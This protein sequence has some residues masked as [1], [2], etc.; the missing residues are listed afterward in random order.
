MK[1][2]R[3]SSKTLGSTTTTPFN[4]V[5]RNCMARRRVEEMTERRLLNA[6][7]RTSRDLL[8]QA[9]PVLLLVVVPIFSR[10]H[11][12]DPAGIGAIPVDRVPQTVAEGDLRLPIQLALRFP[13]VDGV[14]QVVPGT[15]G[16]VADERTRLSEKI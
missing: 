13:A 8:R 11:A 12:G 15:V 1:K 4:T 5:G 7:G 3:S 9:F 16:D 6:N 10:F 2:P 14:A